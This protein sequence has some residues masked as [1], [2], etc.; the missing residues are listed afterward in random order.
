MT[1]E[2][3]I[4]RI[5]KVYGRKRQMPFILRQESHEKIEGGRLEKIVKFIPRG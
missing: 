2:G 1:G 3:E 4:P 5:R